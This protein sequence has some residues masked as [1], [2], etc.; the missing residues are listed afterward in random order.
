MEKTAIK[1]RK[2]PISSVQCH[3]LQIRPNIF[4]KGKNR[5]SMSKLYFIGNKIHISGPKR[6]KTHR[7]KSSSIR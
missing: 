4:E 6:R 2:K 3:H 5:L 1:K 7:N